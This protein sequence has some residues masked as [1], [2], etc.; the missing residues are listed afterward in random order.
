MGL[1]MASITDFGL[2]SDKNSGSDTSVF[3]NK[4]GLIQKETHFWKPLFTFV[5]KADFLKL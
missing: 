1:R 5:C 4:L 3:G 2:R